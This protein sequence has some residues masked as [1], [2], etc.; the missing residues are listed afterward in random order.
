MRQHENIFMRG[1][2]RIASRFAHKAV[3][4]GGRQLAAFQRLQQRRLIDKCAA[5]AID[6][7]RTIGQHGQPRRAHHAGGPACRRAMQRQ[8]IGNRQQ[9]LKRAVIDCALFHLGRQTVLIVIMDFHIQATRVARHHLT[10]PA[11]T[12]NAKTLASDL[13]ADHE[14]GRPEVPAARSDQPLPLDR[15]PGRTQHQQ[16]GDLSRRI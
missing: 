9:A 8:K 1:K 15:A 4:A 10:N 3:K 2:G 5:R 13:L 11:H 6:Q 7:N 16:Q 14:G 12:D